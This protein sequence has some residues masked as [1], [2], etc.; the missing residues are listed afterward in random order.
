MN[1]ISNIKFYDTSSLLL[2]GESLFEENQENKEFFLLSSITI[3]ELKQIKDTN[4]K[5]IE[6]KQSARTILKL[7]DTH[8]D[9]YKIIWHTGINTKQFPMLINNDIRILHD[10]WLA[11]NQEEYKDKIIFVT[12]DVSLKVIALEYF[13]SKKIESIIEEKEEYR[14]YKEVQPDEDVLALFYTYPD[15]NIFGCETNEYLII[16]DMENKVV[17]AKCWTGEKYRH[18]KTQNLSSEWFGNIKPKDIY[19]QLVIDSLYNNKITMVQGPPGSG[20]TMLSLGFLMQQ[21]EKGKIDKIIVFCNTV[22]TINSAKLGYY[23]GD[24]NQK[25]LDSQ[26]GNLLASKLG[27]ITVVEELVASGKLVLLPL[28]DIRG[29]DT[30][31]MNAGVYI[32]E[33]Q[34]MDRTL[35]KLALQRIGEDCICIIDGDFHQQVDDI[36]FAGRNNGMRRVAKIFKGQDFYGQ[37]ELRNIYRSRISQMA[38]L[39]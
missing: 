7:L 4:N 16:R 8:Q 29:Y 20:K 30:S 26:I 6:V 35:M 19:Q 2:A 11:N 3:R 12:N 5:D 36:H 33:A 34:N 27:G 15:T 18:L 24:R 22:A 25:L 38:E 13:D 28:S 21:L 10:A 31:N 9:K 39:I 23:P 14:G 1:F 37:V 32:S 17:E